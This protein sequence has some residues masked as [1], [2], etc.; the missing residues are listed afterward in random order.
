MNAARFSRSLQCLQRR[1][2]LVMSLFIRMI[3]LSIAN[4]S[5]SEKLRAII[6]LR[7]SYFSP[8]IFERLLSE[9]HGKCSIFSSS[10]KSPNCGTNCV[11]PGRWIRSPWAL[12]KSLRR[13]EDML[14]TRAWISCKIT[15]RKMGAGQSVRRVAVEGAD[16]C[17]HYSREPFRMVDDIRTD[18]R[19]NDLL[20]RINLS[21]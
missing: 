20:R 15:V 7:M 5:G 11:M 2:W 16:N 3:S 1:R 9:T 10:R 18:R 13:V 4:R 8:N 6:L 17:V 14:T 12:I 21:E 19:Y